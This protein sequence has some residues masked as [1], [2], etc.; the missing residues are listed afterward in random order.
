MKAV[1]LA[2]GFG[3]RLREKVPN[4]PK[5][6]APVAGRPFLEYILDRLIAGGIAEIVL[7]VGYQANIIIDHFGKAYRDVIVS[8]ALESEPLGT[9]GAIAHALHDRSNDPI[10]V[11]NGDTFLDIDYKELIRWYKG[12]PVPIAMVLRKVQDTSRYGSVLL[13]DERVVG[14]EENRAN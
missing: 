11:L 10:L 8:Y 2:G 3:T 1:V 13:S 7:S 6:M 5:P 9:G 12:N 4:I 14:F